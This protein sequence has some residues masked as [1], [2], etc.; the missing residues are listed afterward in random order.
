MEGKTAMK[1][2]GIDNKSSPKNGNSEVLV[3]DVLYKTMHHFFPSFLNWLKGIEDPRQE[4]KIEYPLS[5]LFWVGTL[6]FQ[7][8]LEARR[9]IN[10]QFNTPD[11]ID[12]LNILRSEEHTSELQSHS[13][14]S[15]AVFCLKKKTKTIHWHILLS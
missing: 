3:K 14:I 9:Q 1:S 5:S 2:Q 4:N 10:F 12:N 13:F 8:K 6:L 15:Y 11:F 7:T